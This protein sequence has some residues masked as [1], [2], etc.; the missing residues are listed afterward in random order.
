VSSEL[1][2]YIPEDEILHSHCCETQKKSYMMI[3]PDFFFAI[4]LCFTRVSVSRIFKQQKIFKLIYSIDLTS[5]HAIEE[6]RHL[7]VTC[8]DL[9]VLPAC[10][11]L[12]TEW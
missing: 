9:R 2:F 8:S 11:A 3:F 7:K 10:L 1:G 4:T 5:L 12:P 6:V